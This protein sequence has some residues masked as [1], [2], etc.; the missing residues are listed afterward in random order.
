MCWCAERDA[1]HEALDNNQL[2]RYLV[3]A[4]EI[5]QGCGVY[6]KTFL[7]AWPELFLLRN[8]SAGA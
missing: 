3:L 2:Y 1:P 7:V 5:S 4:S 8:A 6:L